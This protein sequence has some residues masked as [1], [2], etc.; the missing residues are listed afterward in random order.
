MESTSGGEVQVLHQLGQSRKISVW[1]SA[2][3][4]HL[5]LPIGAQPEQKNLRKAAELNHVSPKN[6]TVSL[7]RR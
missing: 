4:E 6:E 3:R 5:V 1:L 7:R 2:L